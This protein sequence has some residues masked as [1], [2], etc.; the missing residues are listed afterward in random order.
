[1]GPDTYS[2]ALRFHP[3]PSAAALPHPPHPS[4]VRLYYFTNTNCKEYVYMIFAVPPL[5][6][7][8]YKLSPLSL[9]TYCLDT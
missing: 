4:L 8:D 9:V 1:M 7:F 5:T 6:I 3:L 2:Y